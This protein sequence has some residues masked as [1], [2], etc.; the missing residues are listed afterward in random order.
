MKILQTPVRFPP[1]VGG[2][3]NYAYNLSKH[4]AQMGHEVTVVCSD[5]T[6]GEK[7][8]EEFGNIRIKRLPYIGKIANTNITPTLPISLFK[9]DFDVI[10]T[11]IPTPWSADWSGIIS[12]LKRKPFFITYCNDIT[13]IGLRGS[14]AWLYNKTLLKRTLDLSRK[15]IIIQPRYAEYSPILKGYLDKIEAVTPGID[16]GIFHPLD[17][18]KE[19]HDPT[20][21]FLSILDEYHYYKGLD[22]LLNAL[23]LVKKEINNVRLVVGGTGNLLAH[24]ES[25]AKKFGLQE[26][27]SFIGYVPDQELVYY[28]NN[29]DAFILPSTT[30]QE[31][32]GIVLLEAM[33]CGKPV[34]TTRLVGLADD[35]KKTDSGIVIKEN[36]INSLAESII[37]LFGDRV[38]ARKMGINARMLSLDYCWTKMAKKVEKIYL[39]AL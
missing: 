21:F 39:E 4:L 16:T 26:N 9:E 23:S 13:G 6:S 31:G 37:I 28:Y 5:E 33:A 27:V 10:H 12:L 8:L 30:H 19:G 35:I 36:D 1:Y 25:M 32:F 11:H 15:I 38:K 34:I 7:E 22:C 29:C 18:V 14:M 2:V 17:N 24:Y 3:E 20:L